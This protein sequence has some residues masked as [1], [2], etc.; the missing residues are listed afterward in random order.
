MATKV[1]R[2]VRMGHNGSK[3][4]E[5]WL[6]T[7]DHVEVPHEYMAYLTSKYEPTETLV[8]VERRGRLFSYVQWLGTPT[9]ARAAREAGLLTRDEVPF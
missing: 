6:E 1:G 8:F 3:F 7:G 9:E 5:L 4:Q 2:V